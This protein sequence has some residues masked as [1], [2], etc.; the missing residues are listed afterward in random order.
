MTMTPYDYRQLTVHADEARQAEI[1]ALAMRI[2][3]DEGCPQGREE[4]HWLQAER[5]IR[6]SGG[7]TPKSTASFGG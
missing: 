7:E 1:E 6:H 2:W 3:L 5:M 4:Q